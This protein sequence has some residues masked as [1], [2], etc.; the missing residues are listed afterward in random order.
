[1]S[2]RL[3]PGIVDRQSRLGRHGH[4]WPRPQDDTDEKSARLARRRSR[5]SGGERLAP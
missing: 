3:A 1:V 2:I 5:C 4:G